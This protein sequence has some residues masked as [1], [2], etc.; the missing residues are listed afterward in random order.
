MEK[1]IRVDKKN[2]RR[3]AETFVALACDNTGQPIN[4]KALDRVMKDITGQRKF[5]TRLCNIKNDV[6]LRLIFNGAHLMDI[7][8]IVNTESQLGALASLIELDKEIQSL[9]R[10]IKRLTKKGKKCKGTKN[11][12]EKLYKIYKKTIKRFRSILGI[13]KG[14]NSSKPKKKYSLLI[15]FNKKYSGN[16]YESYL[17]DIYDDYDDDEEDEEEDYDIER[18]INSR[19]RGSS[20]V[21]Y[22]RLE[23]DDDE[24]DEEDDDEN[25]MAALMEEQNDKMEK[26]LSALG[27]IL[28]MQTNQQPNH[29]VMTKETANGYNNPISIPNNMD[30][31]LDRLEKICLNLSSQIEG[32]YEDEEDEDEEYITGPLDNEASV[33]LTRML[34]PETEEI[35]QE[36]EYSDTPIGIES[37]SE[38]PIPELIKNRNG[39]I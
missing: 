15:D 20:K 27:A 25:Q 10:K 36:V 22:R 37:H 28:S 33:A 31:R 23:D 9:K 19:K 29:P 2:Y 16:T 35:Y 32:L 34:E 24:E 7:L 5:F 12:Y 30:F 11:R 21:N 4:A 3:V 6:E 38:N 14:S 1:R 17:S 26:V 18:I 39:T 8:N 13:D